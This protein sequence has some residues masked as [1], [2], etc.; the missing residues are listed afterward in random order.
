MPHVLR[1]M[2]AVPAL[3]LRVEQSA[4]YLVSRNWH[5]GGLNR[6]FH[7]RFFLKTQMG[8]TS[9]PKFKDRICLD[10]GWPVRIAERMEKP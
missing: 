10:H 8:G 2:C 6:F 5:H 9:F 7:V 4:T 1:G 3:R